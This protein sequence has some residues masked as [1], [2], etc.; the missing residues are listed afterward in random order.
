MIIDQAEISEQ[1]AISALEKAGYEVKKPEPS[2][3]VVWQKIE[4]E[5][6]GPVQ[7]WHHTGKTIPDKLIQAYE[8]LYEASEQ[9]WKGFP[10]QRVDKS[11]PIPRALIKIRA[12]KA[13]AV[14][15]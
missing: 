9:D 5:G 10:G 2:R 12:I 14:G 8:E 3:K 15:G 13:K 1:S 7:C 6:N 11:I 4:I